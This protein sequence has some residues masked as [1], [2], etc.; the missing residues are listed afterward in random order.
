MDRIP[1][2]LSL[3]APAPTWGRSPPAI[4]GQDGHRTLFQLCLALV[5]GFSLSTTESF[6]LVMGLYN[7]RCS[8]PWTEEEVRHKL[9]DAAG[10]TEVE[11]GYL[12]GPGQAQEQA[13]PRRAELDD[14]SLRAK[15]SNAPLDLSIPG[16]WA[17]Q[18]G[19]ITRLDGGG[20]P[21]KNSIPKLTIPTGRVRD[22]HRPPAP[23]SLLAYRDHLAFYRGGPQRLQGPHFDCSPSRP[24]ASRGQ[25]HGIDHDPVPG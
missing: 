7:P 11:D 8:E 9:T 13:D 4:S 5:K 19:G 3:P 17:F 23:G 24:G 22:R 20:D 25:P 1:A 2:R 18:E 10:S 15:V 12:L 16:S 6:A 14:W 21:S